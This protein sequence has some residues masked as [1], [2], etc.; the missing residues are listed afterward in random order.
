MEGEQNRTRAN[1]GAR[2]DYAST[3]SVRDP[4]AAGGGTYDP[5]E[6]LP[7]REALNSAGKYLGEL[8][9][10]VGNLFSAKLDGIKLSVK[11]LVILAGLGIVGLIIGG[12]VLVTAAVLLLNGLA[13]LLAS[14]FDPPKPWFGQLIVGFIVLAGALGG[15]WFL[16][17]RLTGASK[18][19]T[20]R[21]YQ[22][23]HE[24]QRREYGHDVTERS[25]QTP[26]ASR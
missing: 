3:R 23:M 15:T 4:F 21:K 10:Y 12:S 20:V 11:R 24:Q 6:D 22:V 5:V 16:L 1:G 18:A 8:K 7:P 26:T 17:K 13:N 14:V 19:A 2:E 25:R 9:S